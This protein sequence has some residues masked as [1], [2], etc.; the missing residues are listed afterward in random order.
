MK[1]LTYQS[2]AAWAALLALLALD[3]VSG[4]AALVEE[5]G[6]RGAAQLLVAHAAVDLQRSVKSENQV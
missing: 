5:L 3:G 6:L 4:D 2:V 1:V